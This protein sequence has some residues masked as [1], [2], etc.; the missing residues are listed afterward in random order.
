[1]KKYDIDQIPVMNGNGLVGAVSENGLFKKVFSD[2]EIRNAKIET[3]LEPAYPVVAF[4]TPVERLKASSQK[5]MVQCWQKMRRA[6]SK[7]LLVT[8]LYRAL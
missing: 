3:V 2:P 4:D 1:M 7:S 8:M 5:R 6:I